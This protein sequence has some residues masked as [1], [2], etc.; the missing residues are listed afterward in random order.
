MVLWF[1]DCVYVCMCLLGIHTQPH[2][3]QELETWSCSSV[4][5]VG[6]LDLGQALEQSLSCSSSTSDFAQAFFVHGI[7]ACMH[8]VLQKG[9]KHGISTL[10]HFQKRKEMFWE[11][12][13]HG[14]WLACL[15][16]AKKVDHK[17]TL[18]WNK[19]LNS[20][21]TCPALKALWS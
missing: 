15:L 11:P 14:L 2:Y 12:H 19:S 8:G 3:Y 16:T 20:N 4:T 21:A 5:S 7:S 9:V 17:P 18:K 10:S 1:C 13:S 6:L